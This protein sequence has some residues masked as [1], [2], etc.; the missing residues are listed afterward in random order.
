MSD[1]SRPLGL[2]RPILPRLEEK[3]RLLEQYDFSMIEKALGD[4][5]GWTEDYCGIVA[6]RTKQY[7]ALS[8]LEKHGTYIPSKDVDECWHELVLRTKWYQHLCESVFGDFI[9]HNPDPPVGT[10]SNENR[11]RTVEKLQYW[12]AL[13]ASQ[14]SSDHNNAKCFKGQAGNSQCN[15]VN[16]NNVNCNNVNCNNVNC[17]NVAS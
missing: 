10:M 6:W 11:D 1:T 17:N 12:F 7:L 4:R 5:L 13:G 2:A 16:C 8:L 9:H 14:T 3:L 15:N